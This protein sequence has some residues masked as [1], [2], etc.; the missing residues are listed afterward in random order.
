MYNFP[1]A[2]APWRSND[3]RSADSEL[4]KIDK[5]ISRFSKGIAVISEIVERI[6]VKLEMIAYEFWH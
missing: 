6:S 4:I 2:L 3:L 5:F 1:R